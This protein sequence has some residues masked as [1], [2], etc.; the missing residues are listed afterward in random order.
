[1]KSAFLVTKV[2]GVKIVSSF[3]LSGRISINKLTFENIH[4]IYGIMLMMYY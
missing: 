3:I 2:R 4:G 1:M